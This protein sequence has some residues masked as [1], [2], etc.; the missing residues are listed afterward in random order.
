MSK[1]AFVSG[2]MGLV[3]RHMRRVLEERGW[4]VM[5]CDL[6]PPSY[7]N[8]IHTV[9]RR[10]DSTMT[11]FDLIVHAA[12]HVGG[13]AAIDGKP[14][15]LVQNLHLDAAMFEWAI[16]TQQPH[17]LYFSSSAAYPVGLQ[18]DAA[19]DV[20]LCEDE[21]DLDYPEEPDG[22]YGIAKLI[23]EQQARA[24][25]ECGVN[26]TVVRPFSG[27]AADQDP[28]YPFRAFLERVK[29]GDDPFVIWGSAEQRR[30]WIHIDDVVKGALA[31]VDSGTDESVNLCTGQATSMSDLAR[32][33][34]EGAGH[35]TG[36]DV[37]IVV[38]ETKPMGV[39]NRV[40]D[41]TRFFQYYEPKITIEQGVHDALKEAGL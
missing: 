25:R 34:L 20:R 4:D 1:T 16:V 26:V 8:A 24:A 13:R 12:Y 11:K 2:G 17:V 31:V 28:D 36:S 40:G 29:A 22:R 3:G 23:G 15:N 9:F 37:K 7:S 35:Q 10:H 5:W 18:R 14:G 39:M 21:I 41:P 38:D 6:K 19:A 33:M 32:L 30:D 27:Y